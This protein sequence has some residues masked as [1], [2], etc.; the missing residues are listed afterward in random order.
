[1]TNLIRLMAKQE[2]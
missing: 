1:M 2:T